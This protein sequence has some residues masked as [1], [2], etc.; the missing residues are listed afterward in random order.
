MWTDWQDKCVFVGASLRTDTFHQRAQQEASN[1]AN[2]HAASAGKSWASQLWGFI[3]VHNTIA[4]RTVWCKATACFL[5]CLHLFVEIDAWSFLPLIVAVQECMHIRAHSGR[6][7]GQG[8]QN[9][10]QNIPCGQVCSSVKQKTEAAYILRNL[11]NYSQKGL[12]WPTNTISNPH[13][14]P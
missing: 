6:Q 8:A 5:Q 12:K 7:M 11:P 14:R 9:C 1:T 4:G 3:L 10:W 2:A 13:R